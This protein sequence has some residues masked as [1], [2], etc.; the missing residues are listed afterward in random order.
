MTTLVALNAIHPTFAL[1]IGGALLLVVL[2]WVGWRVTSSLFDRERLI[3]GT[4]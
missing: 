1:A 4:R 2:N 3:L